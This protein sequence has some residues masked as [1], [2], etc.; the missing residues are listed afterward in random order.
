MK[1]NKGWIWTIKD[2]LGKRVMTLNIRHVNEKC[3]KQ[4]N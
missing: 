4:T 3:C 2:T 1:K